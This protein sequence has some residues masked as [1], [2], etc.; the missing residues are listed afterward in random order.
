MTGN[1][2]DHMA[3]LKKVGTLPDEEVDLAQGEVVCIGS[4]IGD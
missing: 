1:K 3:Y 4:R 2:R